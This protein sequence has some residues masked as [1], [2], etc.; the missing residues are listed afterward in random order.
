MV[1]G[2]AVSMLLFRIFQA[3]STH[4]VTDLYLNDGGDIGMVMPHS[5]L[6]TGQYAKWRTGAWRSGG[7]Q[8]ILSVDFSYKTPWDLERLEPNTFFPVP[9]SVVFAQ[10]KG[11]GW[12]ASTTNWRG[13]ALAGQSWH[14]RRQTGCCS[15]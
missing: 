9:A 1:S 13:G 5:A 6:Q 3:C 14:Q 4:G 11:E 15:L 12:Q 2:Q 7:S 10:R 8:G